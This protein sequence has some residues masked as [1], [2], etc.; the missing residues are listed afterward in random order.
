MLGTA[1]QK[2]VLSKLRQAGPTYIVGGAVRDALLQVNC[3]DMDAVTALSLEQ[4][5]TILS[6]SGYHPHRIG[7]KYPTVTVFR[8]KVRLD[9]TA[10]SGNLREDALRR[11]F[12]VNAIYYNTTTEELEDPLSGI[13]DLYS[14]LIRACG[15]ARERF[16]EDPIRVLRMVRLATKFCFRIEPLTW[17]EALVALPA[18]AQTAPERITDEFGKILLTADVIK[19]IN[20]LDKL[21]FFQLFLPELARLKGLEQNHYHSKDVWGHTL[22]VVSNTP[23]NLLLRLAALFHDL[24]KWGT[25]SRE[26]YARGCLEFRDNNYRMG[27]FVLIGNKPERFLNCYAEVLGARL[28]NKPWLIQIKRITAAVPGLNEFEWI[29]A[30]KRHFLG[31]EQESAR[32]V[33]EILPRFRWSM[34][35]H[36]P[37]RN[38]ETELIFLLEHHMRATMTFANELKSDSLPAFLE[39]KSFQRKVRRFVWES[40]WNGRSFV[41]ERVEE[42]LLLWQADL[43]GAKLRE[44]EDYSRFELLRAEIV[45]ACTR[46]VRR[47]AQV[48]W[49]NLYLFAREK[50][51]KGRDL[52]R[53]QEDMRRQLVLESRDIDLDKNYL[54]ARYKDFT[55]H[56][57][58]KLRNQKR[59]N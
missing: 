13:P 20:L 50:G 15:E 9:I 45:K 27:E 36:T 54:E 11:D 42:L 49:D 18:V 39:H 28:D 3:R 21:G 33:R 24:G 32:L 51:L 31:H 1:F 43:W 35:L 16:A 2:E 12:T 25:A 19:G 34:C 7:T 30:G 6:I 37:R 14:G 58:I 59:K 5:E 41:P 48:N 29:P 22:Q 52:G 44:P 40:G 55:S 57:E 38:A 8:D 46:T 23:S 10:F 4:V 56:S 47:L 53:F 26:C 17:Q